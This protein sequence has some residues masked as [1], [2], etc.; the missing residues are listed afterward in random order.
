MMMIQEFVINNTA[1]ILNIYRVYMIF[2][3]MWYIYARYSLKTAEDACE[4]FQSFQALNGS[5]G[6]GLLIISFIIPDTLLLINILLAVSFCTYLFRF[7][8]WYT[9]DEHM[10]NVGIF[11]QFVRYPFIMVIKA[12]LTILLMM[13]IN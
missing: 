9:I 6:V 3:I 11:S 2:K 7:I 4:T 8:Y 1:T 5:I 10:F 12:I 13:I